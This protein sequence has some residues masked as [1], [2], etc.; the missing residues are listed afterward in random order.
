MQ[1]PG[2]ILDQGRRH[3]TADVAGDDRLTEL[4]P[5]DCSRLDPRVD[6]GDQVEL[7]GGEERDLR[8]GAPGV[9]RREACVA[10]EVGGE[11]RLRHRGLLW[12][13]GGSQWRE[14]ERTFVLSG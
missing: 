9:G 6:A 14:T 4:Q 3:A 5:G 1:D 12:L 2:Q 13:V 8:P 11:V 7:L 10:L